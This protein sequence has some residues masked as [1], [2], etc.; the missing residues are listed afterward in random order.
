MPVQVLAHL[1][2]TVRV[3][4]DPQYQLVHQTGS[5]QLDYGVRGPELE[6]KL[7]GAIQK[8][9]RDMELKGLTLYKPP[10]GYLRM[11]DG[12]TVTNPTWMKNPTGE[13][14][15]WY[16]IDWE[17]NRQRTAHLSGGETQLP[18]KRE[19]SLEETDGMVEYRL[20]GIFWAPEKSI[21][22]L[23]DRDEILAEER[24][25]RHPVVFGPTLNSKELTRSG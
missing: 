8:F 13:Y 19:T 22:I 17:G 16:A 25:A 6:R 23:K 1:M 7:Y 3:Q 5:I 9:I 11:P 20:V 15:A 18:K 21:E 2:S 10:G 14:A 4:E 24:A 12:T